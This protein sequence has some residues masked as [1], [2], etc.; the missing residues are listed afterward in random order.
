MTEKQ[1]RIAVRAHLAELLE[2]EI[3]EDDR[4]DIGTA[5]AELR[6]IVTWLRGAR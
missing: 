5:E 4:I 2:G 3:W 6:R 1:Q